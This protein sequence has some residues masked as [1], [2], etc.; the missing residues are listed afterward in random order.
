MKSW[1]LETY[2]ERG[3]EKGKEIYRNGTKKS[4]EIDMKPDDFESTYLLHETFSM[5]EL[6]DHVDKLT[7]RGSE[8]VGIYTAEIYQ[9]YTY[10]FSV[11]LLTLIGVVISARKSREGPGLKLALG[12]ALAFV[13]IIFVITSRSMANVG[14]M[15]PLLAAW[16]PN[17]I[18]GSIGVWL[19]TKVPK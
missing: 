4:I 13:Y 2:N 17:I 19:Y 8:D 5:G 18:F 15:G 1:F 6:S 3:F 11:V 7:L 14:S 9:R 10:P 16:L 12:F